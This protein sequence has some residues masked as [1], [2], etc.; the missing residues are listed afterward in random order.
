MGRPLRC[1]EQR[2]IQLHP[3]IVGP[4]MERTSERSERGR[5]LRGVAN[6]DQCAINDAQLVDK[7]VIAVAT[8]IHKEVY[9]NQ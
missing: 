1:I 5:L 4:K 9:I 7:T 3:A 6:Y 8:G 2:C